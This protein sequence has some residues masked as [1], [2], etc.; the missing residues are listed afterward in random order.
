M[1]VT[2]SPILVLL[3]SL[4]KT[5]SKHLAMRALFWKPGLC[6]EHIVICDSSYLAINVLNCFIRTT[7][8]VI[9]RWGIDIFS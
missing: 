4:V 6:Y 2:V 8:Y 9:Y 5:R 1:F 7:N 3:S